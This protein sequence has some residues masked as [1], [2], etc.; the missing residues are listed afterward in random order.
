[1]MKIPRGICICFCERKK[2]LDELFCYDLRNRSV[3]VKRNRA[4]NKRL[5]K[6]TLAKGNCR[7]MK[8]TLV[9]MI[10]YRV[11]FFQS[12]RFAFA[13]I[14]DDEMILIG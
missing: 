5:P 13:I 11:L 12:F 14:P 2:N 7:K 6:I 3:D 4:G 9:T 10:K 8:S 1:M